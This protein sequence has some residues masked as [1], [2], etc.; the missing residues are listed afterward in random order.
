MPHGLHPISNLHTGLAFDNN[1]CFV[2]TLS[3]CDTLHDT[4]DIVYQDSSDLPNP[5]I[6]EESAILTTLFGNWRRW[7]FQ[8]AATKIVSYYKKPKIT[9]IMTRLDDPKRKKN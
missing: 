9:E 5:I 8:A 7:G 1:D 6:N 3:G 2:E 4:V